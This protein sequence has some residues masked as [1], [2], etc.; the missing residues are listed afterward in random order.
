MHSRRFEG[1]AG[2]PCFA[3]LLLHCLCVLSLLCTCQLGCTRLFWL[4]GRCQECSSIARSFPHA[5]ARI[6]AV[7]I[8][9][10]ILF[11]LFD[12]C[13]SVHR[14][15]AQIS[16]GLACCLTDVHIYGDV[17]THV[18]SCVDHWQCR[19][20]PL[21]LPPLRVTLPLAERVFPCRPV[22]AS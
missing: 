6:H 14:H 16:D 17:A 15:R 12:H 18:Y 8:F 13:C 22:P 10:H 1:A 11:G 3:R 7:Q 2:A 19:R 21:V 5:T 4:Q 9:W 20:S